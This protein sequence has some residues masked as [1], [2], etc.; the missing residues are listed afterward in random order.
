MLSLQVCSSRTLLLLTKFM[1]ELSISP[2]RESSRSWPDRFETLQAPRRPQLQPAS[3][4]QR[5]G[6]AAA[7]WRISLRISVGVE[8]IPGHRRSCTGR[9]ATVNFSCGTTN[10][11]QEDRLCRPPSPPPPHSCPGVGGWVGVVGRSN[12][13]TKVETAP[14]ALATLRDQAADCVVRDKERNKSIL[15]SLLKP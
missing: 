1:V 15:T 4:P 9:R 6:D 5:T 7:Q 2:S 10:C 8:L 11:S 12:W 13:C 14:G 3:G